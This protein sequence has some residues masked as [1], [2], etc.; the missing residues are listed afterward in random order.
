MCSLGYIS[1]VEFEGL[2]NYPVCFFGLSLKQTPS[3]KKQHI[4]AT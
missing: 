3:Q 2:E 1:H 4:F